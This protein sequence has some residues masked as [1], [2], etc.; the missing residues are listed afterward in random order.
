MHLLRFPN[1]GIRAKDF[2]RKISF[3][4]R[5]MRLNRVESFYAFLLHFHSEDN[6]EEGQQ[7]MAQ[8]LAKGRLAAARPPARGGHPQG[9]QPSAG[10]TDCGQTARGGCPWRA[11][12]GRPTRGQPCRLRRG[13]G[14]G[15]VE[16]GKER[17]RASF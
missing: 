10:T 13:S 5:V 8:P 11:Y 6:E 16:G 4:P 15:D 12:K 7:G 2:V 3:K 17:A 1:S 14:D 9:Q